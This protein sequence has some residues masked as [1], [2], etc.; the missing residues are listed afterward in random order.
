MIRAEQRARGAG[1]FQREAKV[2]GAMPRRVQ[3]RDAPIRTRHCRAISQNHVRPEIMIAAF[4]TLFRWRHMRAKAIAR[5][6][7]RGLQRSDTGRM[8]AMRMRDQNM[9]NALT[10]GGVQ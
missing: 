1:I 9:R 3:R 8:I 6:T 5:R 10:F 2:I 4:A 7:G